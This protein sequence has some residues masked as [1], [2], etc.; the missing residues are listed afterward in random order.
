MRRGTKKINTGRL[1]PRYERLPFHIPFLAE[2][3]QLYFA[4]L[5]KI[6]LFSV[7]GMCVRNILLPERSFQTSK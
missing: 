7:I 2:K 5:W 4:F 3:M 6:V 1:R